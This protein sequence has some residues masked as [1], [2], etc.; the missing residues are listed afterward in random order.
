MYGSF[1]RAKQS[2]NVDRCSTG[3]SAIF[4]KDNVRAAT[5]AIIE[6]IGYNIFQSPKR[7]AAHPAIIGAK[8]D[9]IA[10]T[11]W[12]KVRVLANLFPLTIFDTKGF[13]ETCMSVLPIPNNEK[14]MS[15]TKKL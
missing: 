9:A 2:P 11:N 5:I 15:M 8:K 3:F 6:K 1:N 7:I 13:R 12:P 4:V 14:A 10:F